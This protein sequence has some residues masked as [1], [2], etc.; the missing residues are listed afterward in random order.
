LDNPLGI[1]FCL[2]SI[3]REVTEAQSLGAAAARPDKAPQNFR[4]DNTPALEEEYY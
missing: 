2:V 3:P 4:A 1:T